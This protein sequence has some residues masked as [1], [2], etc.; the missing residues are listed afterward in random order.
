MKKK[1]IFIAATGQ[2]VGK[3]TLC[4]GILSGLQKRFSTVGFFK[5]VGQQHVQITDELNVD[6]DVV[7][8]KDHFNLQSSY[9]SMSPVL[10]PAGFTRDYLDQKVSEAALIQKIHVSFSEI[11]QKHDYV[12]VEGTGHVGVGSLFNLNNA[13]VAKAL[14]IDIV[15]IANAGLGSTIDELALNI[16][17]CKKHDVNIRGIILNRVLDDK[18]DM[19]ADYFP[20]AL[21]RWKIPLIGLIPF[22]P[23]LSTPT[24]KDF[25]LLFGTTLISGEAFRFRHFSQMRLVAGSLESY[26]AEHKSNELIITPA[27]REDIVLAT[28]ERHLRAKLMDDKEFKG[29]MILTSKNPPRKEIINKIKG[30]DL[31]ILYAPLCSFDVM[32]M[33]TSFTAKIRQEDTSKIEKAI[34]LVESNIDYS[35]L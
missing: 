15:L 34:Q 26:L 21:S 27:C 32:K 6:K 3:T 22:L 28:L 23:Y 31:P 11:S 30:T 29:G 20:K 8:F 35:M 25:E 16:E 4:L 33:I 17:M 7:L 19:I 12:L 14:G 5:P 13:R 9:P 1:A 24:M 2:H 18:R 10:C